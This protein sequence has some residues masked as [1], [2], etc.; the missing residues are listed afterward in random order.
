MM[1]RASL[2][3]VAAVGVACAGVAFT[4]AFHRSEAHCLYE[5]LIRL[6]RD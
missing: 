1:P 2:I 4:L 5:E 6:T 3:A